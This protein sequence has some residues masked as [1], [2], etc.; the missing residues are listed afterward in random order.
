M[1]ELSF[2]TQH[3]EHYA[4]RGAVDTWEHYGNLWKRHN[5][6]WY[7]EASNYVHFNVQKLREIADKLESLK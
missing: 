2:L 5:G 1:N 3:A 7:F 4:V 6:T